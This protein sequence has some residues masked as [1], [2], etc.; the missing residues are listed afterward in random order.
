MHQCVTLVLH[1]TSVT[2]QRLVH[3]ARHGSRAPQPTCCRHHLGPQAR[4]LQPLP[5]LSCRSGSAV[6]GRLGGPLRAEG[7]EPLSGLCDGG[8][9]LRHVQGRCRGRPERGCAGY[10]LSPAQTVSI[11]QANRASDA[12]QFILA[13]AHAVCSQLSP[14]RITGH[15]P[16]DRSPPLQ[17]RTDQCL[18]C[19]S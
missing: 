5:R 12:T 16:R 17:F 6:G 3:P 14:L 9:A 4:P 19:L 10:V 8:R 15:Q 18:R 2:H 7:A 13:D 1:I 11:A